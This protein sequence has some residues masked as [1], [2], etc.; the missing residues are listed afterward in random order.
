MGQLLFSIG[1]GENKKG[2]GDIGLSVTGATLDN[3]IV[4][5][6]QRTLQIGDEV[7]IKIIEAKT[8]DLPEVLQ[9]AQRDTS[10]YEKAYVRRMAKEFGWIIS[11]GRR[12]NPRK[13]H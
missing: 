11:T 7:R 10:K 8:P 5:W 12:P 1:C 6:E 4:R 3:E 2:R 9:P 13:A